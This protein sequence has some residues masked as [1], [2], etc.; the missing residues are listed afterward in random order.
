MPRPPIA[1]I[2]GLAADT[3]MPMGAEERFA[4]SAEQRAI[5]RAAFEV[6]QR[7]GG[8][9]LLERGG[10]QAAWAAALGD[11]AGSGAMAA[12]TAISAAGKWARAS[13]EDIASDLA[14]GPIGNLVRDESGNLDI[15]KLTQIA[16]RVKEEMVRVYSGTVG[17]YDR[18]DL[19]KANPEG[20]YGPGYYTT[21][22]PQIAGGRVSEPESGWAAR[23]GREDQGGVNYGK[24]F[25]TQAEALADATKQRADMLAQYSGLKPKDVPMPLIVERSQTGGRVIEPGYAQAAGERA[26][27]GDQGTIDSLQNNIARSDARIADM[28]RAADQWQRH[29]ARG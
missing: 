28:Q 18:A 23:Y 29:Q 21:D 17:E 10:T 9:G 7:A 11:K 19:S 14:R 15:D 8:G 12:R 26:G 4:A 27:L 24:I 3:I 16:S 5:N 1:D 22:N 13:I 25:P 2:V 20:L 6:A